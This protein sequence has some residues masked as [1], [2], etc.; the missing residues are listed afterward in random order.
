MNAMNQENTSMAAVE[1]QQRRDFL[2]QS[3]L[4]GGGL[5]LGSFWTQGAQAEQSIAKP[6]ATSTAAS[7]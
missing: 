1:D 7:F 4:L 6:Q 3:S 5:V 2:R